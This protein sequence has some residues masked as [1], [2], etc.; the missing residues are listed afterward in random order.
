MS[1]TYLELLEDVKHDR[2]SGAWVVARKAISCLEIF[3]KA[4][5]DLGFDDFVTEVERIAREIL[6]AQPG[7]AQLTNVFNLV[8][9]TIA[10]ETSGNT[11][12]LSRKIAGEAQRFDEYAKNAVSKVAEYGAEL[13]T[14]DA[15]VMI[16]SNSSTV[17][18][19]LRKALD[20]GKSFHVVL[21]ESRPVGEGKACAEELSK[22]GVQNSF[23]IDAAASKGIERADLVLLGADAL[24]EKSLVNKIG[25]N[26]ICLLAREAVVPCYAAGESTKFI[27]QKLRRKKEQPRDPLEVW[28]NPPEETTVESYY[29]DDV[30]LDLFTGIITEDGVLTPSELGGRIRAQKMNAKLL[31]MLK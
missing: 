4:K 2:R 9:T 22:L 19:I 27:P 30:P 24:S 18:E 8:L 21:T 3:S 25:S 17:F 16:H 29:F 12:V 7:M 14:A 11:V 5:A 13:I 1:V 6:K 20:D 26:A 10:D 31:E 15:I 23:I 28:G